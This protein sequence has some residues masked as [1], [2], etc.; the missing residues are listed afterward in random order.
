MERQHLLRRSSRPTATLLRPSQ[1]YFR[2]RTPQHRTFWELVTLKEALE[3]EAELK[4]TYAREKAQ[5]ALNSAPTDET[6]LT[7]ADPTLLSTPLPIPTRLSAKSLITNHLATASST[8]TARRATLESAMANLARR[9]DTSIGFDALNARNLRY[10]RV[11]RFRDE[12]EKLRAVALAQEKAVDAAARLSWQFKKTVPA[13]KVDFTPVPKPYRQQL[14]DRVVRGVYGGEKVKD[15][16][17]MK[18]VDRVERRMKLRG[19]WNTVSTKMMVEYI[20][21]MLPEGQ[22][23]RQGR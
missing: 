16:K 20:R 10:G 5:L 21:H 22:S 9:E 8:P 7:P 6:A 11:M 13:V 2:A 1:S 3:H 4:A 19:T 12:D 14:V 15:T 17:G 18:E 23:S